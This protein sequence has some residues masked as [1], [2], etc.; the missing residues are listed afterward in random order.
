MSL[1]IKVKTAAYALAVPLLSGI[2][3]PV[4]INGQQA[5]PS[6]REID[7]INRIEFREW[8]PAKINTVLVPLGPIEAEDLIGSD[9]DIIAPMII[10]KK[11]APR[12]NAMIAPVI[13]YSFAGKVKAYPAM[14]AV[15]DDSYRAYV[16]AVLVALAKSKFKN[17]ILLNGHAGDQS[18]LLSALAQEVAR[19]T[20]TRILAVNWSSYYSDVKMVGL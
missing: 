16:R 6:T 8:V 10:A 14:A 18:A 4:S 19:E 17:I 7:H 20:G 1:T 12:V 9:A 2:L 11:I 15:A 3:L 5:G 13:P